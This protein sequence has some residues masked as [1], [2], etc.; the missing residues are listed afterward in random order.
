MAVERGWRACEH[1]F[2]AE[3]FRRRISA[4]LIVACLSVTAATAHAQESAEAG[5]EPAV[6]VYRGATLIDVTG[7]PARTNTA[8]VVRGERIEAIVDAANYRAPKGAETVD[9]AGR[10]LVPGFINTHVH[11]AAPPDRAYALPI[12]QREIYGG[13]TAVRSMGDDARA[14]GELARAAY[15]NEIPGPDIVYV[16]LF[17]GHGFFDDP[18]VQSTGVVAGQTPWMREITAN[19]DLAE[20]VTL[21]RGTGASGIKI[22]ANLD[23]ASVAR[24]VAEAHRQKLKAWSHG[25]VFPAT[26]LDAVLAGADSLSHICML[27]YQAQ[28]MPVTYHHRADVDESRFANGMPAAVEDVFTA[29]KERGTVLDATLYVYKTIERMRAEFPP[30]EGPPTYCSSALAGRIAHAAHAAG[31]EFAV[32]TDSLTPDG[33]PYPAV[34]EEMQ[35]LVSQAGMSPLEALRSATLIGARGLGRENEMGTIEPGKLANLVFLASD[36][37]QDISATRQ[38]VLTVKRGQRYARKDYLP[39]SAKPPVQQTQ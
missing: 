32:G 28:P 15:A 31:V 16:A 2:R 12:M 6:V 8:I 26:P 27:A 17:A 29:M 20:A 14:I 13:V 24:I 19:T 5:D 22:Y 34:Q 11:L 33:E 37:S 36:P 9:V 21:A 18:R 3:N 35:L 25:A 1:F 10:Y 38:V 23:A 4:A 7:G 30:G 39:P